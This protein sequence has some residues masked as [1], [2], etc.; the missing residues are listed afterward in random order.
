MRSLIQ[1]AL[2]PVLGI[3]LIGCMRSEQSSSDVGLVVGK[4]A[5]E[6][7]GRD[8]DGKPI[9][10]S[11]LQGKVVLLDFWQTFCPPCRVM[12]ARERALVEQYKGRPFVVLGVNCDPTLGMLR[13]SSA[14]ENLTWHCVWDG[15]GGPNFSL[16]GVR[17]TPTVFLLDQQ[18]VIRFKS[19]GP[20]DPQVLE[21]QIIQLLQ[22]IS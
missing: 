22:E 3:L 8:H 7:S 19:V 18:G 11:E 5:P 6:V 1:L 13:E 20:P 2:L 10:L 16:W 9:K 4:V 15:A 12:H 14:K 21:K 17:Q